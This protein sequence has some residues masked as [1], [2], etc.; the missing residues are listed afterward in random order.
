MK[1]LK[2]TSILIFS[3]FSSITMANEQPHTWHTVQSQ[4]GRWHAQLQMINQKGSFVS[5][6]GSPINTF[7]ID[8]NK[9][10]DYGFVLD[11]DNDFDV[12]YT[13]TLVKE[14]SEKTKQFSSKTCVY[15]ITASSPAQPD[16]RPSSFNGAKCEWIINHGIGEDFI[17]S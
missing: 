5:R 10:Q 3:L 14:E 11:P 8:L 7:T 12:A 4:N 9:P 2:S 1:L 16:I 13:L 6:D 17:V 15:V